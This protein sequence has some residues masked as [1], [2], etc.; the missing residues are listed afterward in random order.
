MVIIGC[1]SSK[2]TFGAN[3][4]YL[5]RCGIDNCIEFRSWASPSADCCVSFDPSNKTTE[6]DVADIL[7]HF[8]PDGLSVVEFTD[9][10][11]QQ[12]GT[13]TVCSH[14]NSTCGSERLPG[15]PYPSNKTTVWG[16]GEGIFFD[17]LYNPES[18]RT[19]T[20]YELN[21]LNFD[22]SGKRNKKRGG[23]REHKSRNGVRRTIQDA[24]YT[25]DPCPGDFVTIIEPN[26]L[27]RDFQASG[28][29]SIAPR[30][31]LD[32]TCNGHRAP[33]TMRSLTDR[34]LVTF[35]SDEKA[36]GNGK[37]FQLVAK[38]V[39]CSVPSSE[40]C[41][42][43]CDWKENKFYQLSSL[44]RFGGWTGNGSDCGNEDPE[45]PDTD[46]CVRVQFTMPKIPKDLKCLDDC[47][48][49]LDSKLNEG[50]EIDEN[51]GKRPLDYEDNCL[52]FPG[53]QENRNT[54]NDEHIDCIL[55][56]RVDKKSTISLRERKCIFSKSKIIAMAGNGVDPDSESD[57]DCDS[58]TDGFS[59]SNT[60]DAPMRNFVP[61]EPMDIAL[62]FCIMANLDARRRLPSPEEEAAFPF[63]AGERVWSKSLFKT[64]NTFLPTIYSDDEEEKVEEG[65]EVQTARNF[66]EVF[67]RSKFQRPL[68]TLPKERSAGPTSALIER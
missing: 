33:L 5:F 8:Y 68:R 4:I 10:E 47:F 60:A 35:R 43:D 6:T 1:R 20:C 65:S 30:V 48:L 58:D 16:I 39:N 51:Y 41:L 56:N 9:L 24:D 21:F 36:K 38:P 14:E 57:E 28:S 59:V 26:P 44:W 15:D 45:R 11:A 18:Q 25:N 22:V 29:Y 32:R 7:T 2:S 34:I 27:D 64:C 53:M 17:Y 67:R 54:S 31:I 12:D 62:M 42:W 37:G 23:R 40:S 13:Y 63:F 52:N 66:A 49:Q 61:K 46:N 55:L 3:D 50:K 19:P